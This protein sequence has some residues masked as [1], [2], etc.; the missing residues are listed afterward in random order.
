MTVISFVPSDGS[1]VTNFSGDLKDF[2]DFLASE[3]GYDESQYLVSAGGGTETFEG[4]DA[5]FTTSGYSIDI[6]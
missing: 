4:S 3:Q 5:V 2:F 1:Q 6:A